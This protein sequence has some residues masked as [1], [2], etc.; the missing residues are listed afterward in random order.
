[1]LAI[2]IIIVLFFFNWK[3]WEWLTNLLK[4][5]GSINIL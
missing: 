4:D 5:T 2:I 1:M 3:N